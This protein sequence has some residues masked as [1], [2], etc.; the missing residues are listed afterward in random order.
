[1]NRAIR[2]A[3]EKVNNTAF[4]PRRTEKT[5]KVNRIEKRRRDFIN[6]DLVMDTLKKG[7]VDYVGDKPYYFDPIDAKGY[8][9]SS[10]LEGWGEYWEMLSRKYCLHLNTAVFQRLANC[11]KYVTPIQKSLI[12][13]AENAVLQQKQIYLQIPEDVLRDTV[14]TA[15]IRFE[16]E[17]VSA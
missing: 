9:L 11:L 8:E 5:L 2:R 15:Q 17:K 7:M 10:A 6:I 12:V 4:S 13:E 16:F 14:T 1:M 3:M